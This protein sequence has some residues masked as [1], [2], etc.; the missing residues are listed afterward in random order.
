MVV[1]LTIQTAFKLIH[2]KESN[3]FKRE[4]TTHSVPVA[5]HQPL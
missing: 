2:G 4:R 1:V 3:L 5:A